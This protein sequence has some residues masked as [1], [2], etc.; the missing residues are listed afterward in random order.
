MGFD[1]YASPK[2]KLHHSLSTGDKVGI[3]L[4]AGIPGLVL[5]IFFMLWQYKREA[6]KEANRLPDYNLAS[7]DPV[8]KYRHASTTEEEAEGGENGG[9]VTLSREE[10]DEGFRPPAYEALPGQP[11]ENEGD[12]GNEG[13]M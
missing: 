2:P 7:L 11:R 1:C 13:R 10:P 5:F 8:P 9:P 12:W 4:G 6:A 3:G